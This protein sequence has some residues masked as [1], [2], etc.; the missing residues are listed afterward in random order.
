MVRWLTWVVDLL[1]EPNHRKWA[2][3]HRRAVKMYKS[4]HSPQS[5]AEF[6]TAC[7]IDLGS[8][9]ERWALAIRHSFA[10]VYRIH[11]HWIR[12]DERLRALDVIPPRSYPLGDGFDPLEFVFALERDVGQDVSEAAIGAFG[13][14]LDSRKGTVREFVKLFIERADASL[15][16]ERIDVS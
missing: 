13:G 3:K 14:V 8:D 11:S 6:V 16:G 15:V 2:M 7:E 5:D 12:A 4:S 1:C 10:R 9:Y